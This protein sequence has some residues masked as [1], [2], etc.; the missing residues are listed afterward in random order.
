MTEPDP[1]AQ[2]AVTYFDGRSSRRRAV[3][4]EFVDT[5][6]IVENGTTVA[7]YSNLDANSG[8]AQK[9]IDLSAYA[10]KTVTLS[11]SGTEDAYLQTSFV[12]DDVALNAG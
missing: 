11:F 1:R 8:Y 5:L 3:E 6:D 4:L 2:P 7:S 12:L 9:S 10:G